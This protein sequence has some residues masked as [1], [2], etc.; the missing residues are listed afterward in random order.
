MHSGPYHSSNYH[1]EGSKRTKI[2]TLSPKVYFW[3]FESRTRIQRKYPKPPIP[4]ICSTNSDLEGS[5]RV[6]RECQPHLTL[7]RHQPKLTANCLITFSV[8]H[9][10]LG[11]LTV[12]QTLDLKERQSVVS[13]FIFGFIFSCLQ[14]T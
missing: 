1:I 8:K 10:I 6:P 3:W 7:T 5:P 11:Y 13:F 14:T 2:N 9:I 4:Y 12:V